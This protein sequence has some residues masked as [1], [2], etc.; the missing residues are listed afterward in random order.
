MTGSVWRSGTPPIGG[1]PADTS[2]AKVP[3][4]RRSRLT[5]GEM[6]PWNLHLMPPATPRAADESLSVGDPILGKSRLSRQCDTCVFAHDNKMHRTGRL[7]GLVAEARGRESIIVCHSTLPHYKL[8]GD[9]Q[10][11]A[12]ALYR[13]RRSAISESASASLSASSAYLSGNISRSR[14]TNMTSAVAS[15]T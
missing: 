7:R 1:V 15:T 9:G 6:T 8:P 13:R 3:D 2:E 14:S 10:S 4:R 11:P 12:A 5:I